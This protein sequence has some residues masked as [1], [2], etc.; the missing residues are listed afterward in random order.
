M[1]PQLYYYVIGAEFIDLSR[2]Q[3]GNDQSVSGLLEELN[4]IMHAISKNMINSIS[5]VVAIIMGIFIGSSWQAHLKVV[6]F[7]SPP[8]WRKAESSWEN[9]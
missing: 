8:H 7:T 4:E 1:A 6:S 2:V 3:S 9:L 5:I